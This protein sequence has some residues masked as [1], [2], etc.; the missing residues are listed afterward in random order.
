M[1]PELSQ[2]APGLLGPEDGALGP[3][4]RGGGDVRVDELQLERADDDERAL[5]GPA[6]VLEHRVQPHLH[7]E[8]ARV[9][10]RP[11]LAHPG[12]GQLDGLAHA[13]DSHAQRRRLPRLVLEPRHG[14]GVIEA[15]AVEGEGHG[16][17]TV[18]DGPV[19][20]G[21]PERHRGGDVE[22]DGGVGRR[23]GGRQRE[24]L[25]HSVV[26]R[27]LGREHHAEGEHQDGD[28][29]SH[30]DDGG[31]PDGELRPAAVVTAAVALAAAPALPERHG[32][33]RCS[34][35]GVVGWGTRILRGSG[36]L[37]KARVLL[38]VERINRPACHSPIVIVEE[39][40]KEGGPAG[41]GTT[42]KTWLGSSPDAG[43]GGRSHSGKPATHQ[44]EIL[45]KWKG[46]ASEINQDSGDGLC[47]WTEMLLHPLPPAAGRWLVSWC[48]LLGG[49]PRQRPCQ[50][51]YST[52]SVTK[53]V[54]V[55]EKS[56]MFNFNQIFI[57]L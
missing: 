52:Y 5:G 26:G 9:V 44:S 16:E 34:G 43:H 36:W 7:A 33:P 45:E 38:G 30:D 57:Y 53:L 35:V 55:L 32:R 27:G 46:I 3:L 39:R 31:G 12:P 17:R 29:A 28:E 13:A 50:I 37:S 8:A 56:I 24:P 40:I 4:E 25:Q 15:G 48:T 14:R 19:H 18:L 2:L 1:E 22:G 54:V 49:G 51:G 6:L 10:L 42:T 23:V 41:Q 47:R 20:V 11:E 21:I